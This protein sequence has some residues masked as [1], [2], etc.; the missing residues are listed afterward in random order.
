MEAI[1]PNNQMKTELEQITE[2]IFTAKELGDMKELCFYPSEFVE[3][4][5]KLGVPSP[6]EDDIKEDGKYL[7]VYQDKK[8]ERFTMFI[9]LKIQ[10][11]DLCYSCNHK[12]KRGKELLISNINLPDFLEVKDGKNYNQKKLI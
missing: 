10:S 7:G 11:I 4:C 6:N 2:K 9:S 3:F 12:I 8:G 5:D 1:K